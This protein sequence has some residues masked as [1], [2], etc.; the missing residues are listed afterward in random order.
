MEEE[1]KKIVTQNIRKYRK[2]AGLT[3]MEIA[4]KLNLSGPSVNQWENGISF[5][6]FDK[7]YKLCKILN[8]SI[9]DLLGE[10][11]LGTSLGAEDR[12]SLATIKELINKIKI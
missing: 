2:M 5:P 4:K 3:Q 6:E 7:I 1:I 9:D 11:S 12:N 8:I 10:Y